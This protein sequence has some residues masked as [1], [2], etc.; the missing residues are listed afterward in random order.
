MPF[1]QLIVIAK[2]KETLQPVRLRLDEPDARAMDLTFVSLTTGL[3]AAIWFNAQHVRALRASVL[4]LSPHLT[5]KTRCLGL[6]RC[7]TWALK[8]YRLCAAM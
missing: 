2:L 1:L 6:A 4:S 8:Y 3:R 7:K 5:I